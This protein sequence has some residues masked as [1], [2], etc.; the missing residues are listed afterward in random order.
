MYTRNTDLG[1]CPHRKP[2]ETDDRYS[3]FFDC[4]VDE[5]MG[6][7]NSIVVLHRLRKK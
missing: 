4:Q 6:F 3:S 2:F 7:R 5:T 1:L